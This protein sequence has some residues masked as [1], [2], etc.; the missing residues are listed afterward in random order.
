M[1][2]YSMYFTGPSVSVAT[3]GDLPSVRCQELVYAL[4]TMSD[5]PFLRENLNALGF[6]ELFT[7]S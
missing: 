1:A 2:N 6:R 5:E 4:K 7:E 3:N